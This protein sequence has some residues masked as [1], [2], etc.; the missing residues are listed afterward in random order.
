MIE[1]MTDAITALADPAEVW[2]LRRQT[3][4]TV[5][6][7]GIPEVT[8]TEIPLEPPVVVVPNTPQMRQLL[9]VNETNAGY[10][11]FA[12]QELRGPIQGREPDHATDGTCT[13]VITRAWPWRAGNFY[14]GLA[15]LAGG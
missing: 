7:D 15:E 8:R 1:D 5:Y 6:V 10:L 3:A 11:I 2:T 13:Y 12:T 14:V 9:E 4:P